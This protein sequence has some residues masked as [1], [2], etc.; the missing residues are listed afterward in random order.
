MRFNPDDNGVGF[1]FCAFLDYDKN[2]DVCLYEIGSY[3]CTPGYSYGPIVRPRGIIHYVKSGKGKL[4]IKDKEHKVH[5]GQI[6]LIPP[7]VRAYYAADQDDPWN[8]CWLHIGG[9]LFL[10][11]L[12]DAGINEDNPVFDIVD[13][14]GDQYLHFIEILEQ[15]FNCYE[16]EYSSLAKMYE[17]LDYFNSHS[18]V[19]RNSPES[20]QL[21]YVHTV[22]KYIQLKYSEPL[23]VNEI[24]AAC[25][26]NRSYLSR[27][28]HDATGST[29]KDY[30]L[31]YR[32]NEAEKLLLHSD[33]PISYIAFAVGYSDIYTFTKAFKK[34]KNVTPSEYRKAYT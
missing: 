32:M 1:D 4:I 5:Q 3:V 21:E 7:R 2:P 11:A 12:K 24:A 9:T 34:S 16:R 19:D 6:F 10:E 22:I 13:N 23:H 20:L 33:Q 15:L 27:L 25:N 30:L 14:N 29:I 31:S 8:Y 28:F 18:K 17:L 26:L